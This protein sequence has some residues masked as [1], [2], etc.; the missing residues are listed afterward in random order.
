[1]NTPVTFKDRCTFLSQLLHFSQKDNGIYREHVTVYGV[2]SLFKP[3][4]NWFASDVECL[5]V[6][7]GMRIQDIS[8]K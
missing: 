5:A 1:M 7:E 4:R 8:L 2:R 6:I 3:G